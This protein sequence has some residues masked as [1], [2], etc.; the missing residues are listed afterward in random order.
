MRFALVLVLALAG[1]ATLDTTKMSARCRD[2]YNACLTGC[3]RPPH[4]FVDPDN[5]QPDL[6][7][8]SCVDQCNKDA[9][10]CR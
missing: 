7:T 9:K 1:C 6:V 5:A 8:P 2:L 4:N 10:S 3:P